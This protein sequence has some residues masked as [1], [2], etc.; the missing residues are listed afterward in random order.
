MA[1]E[2]LRIAHPLR[3]RERDRTGAL[4]PPGKAL[5]QPLDVL[6]G[7]AVRDR[8]PPYAN[9][10]QAT[11]SRSP[12]DLAETASRAVADGFAGVKI[13]PF[14]QPPEVAPGRGVA[15]TREER[16]LAEARVRAV[17][18]AIGPNIDLHTDWAWSVTPADAAEMAERLGSYD[19]FW[20]E[21]PFKTDDPEE[22]AGLRHRIG[23]RLAGGEQLSTIL[24][25]RQ[26]FE[27][28]ALDVVMPD[29]KWIGGISGFREVATL[30][31]AYDVEVSPHNMS[32]PVATAG[33]V[34]LSAVLNNFLTL[35]Y[36]YAGIPWRNEL[37]RD[38]E[39]VL[40]GSIPLPM[41]PGLGIEW[42]EAAARRLSVGS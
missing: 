39:V 5:D 15:L 35:E 25:F 17:R 33:S 32:G 21:E 7:G 14:P 24:P 8:I 27:A 10:S 38:T 37:V 3:G 19:L 29:V 6:L 34:H 40:D 30:A 22:F 18:T 13:Y 41:S 23:P 16:E 36:G 26:L 4:G 1:G 42:D 28:R 20:I 9:L 2:P 31:A 11:P 12:R